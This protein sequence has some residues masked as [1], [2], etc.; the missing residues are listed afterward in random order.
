MDKNGK[1][2]FNKK[3]RR[4][5]VLSFFANLPLCL[6]GLEACGGAHYRVTEISKLDAGHTGKLVSPRHVK[7]FAL[8]NK[9]DMA[10]ARP[11]C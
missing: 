3:L 1:D 2:V 4:K 10:D 7:P 5:N 8:N 9:T 6:I 11:I